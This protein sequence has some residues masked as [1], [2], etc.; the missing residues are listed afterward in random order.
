MYRDPIILNNSGDVDDDGSVV[1]EM[2]LPEWYNGDVLELKE[3]D[4]VINHIGVGIVR[5]NKSNPSDV[6]TIGEDYMFVSKIEM[7]FQYMENR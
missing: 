7:M 1:V 6:S 2:E 3:G 4:V 5:G